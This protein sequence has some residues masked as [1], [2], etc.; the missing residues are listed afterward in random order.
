MTEPHLNKEGDKNMRTLGILGGM[1]HQATAYF[2]EMLSAKNGGK[3]CPNVIIYSKGT[4][5]NL[6]DFVLGKIDAVDPTEGLVEAVKLLERSGATEIVVPSALSHYFL[7]VLSEAVNIPVINMLAHVAQTVADKGFTNVGLLAKEATVH[8]N[9]YQQE[10]LM[11]GI[12]TQTPPADGQVKMERIISCLE[13]GKSHDG[14]AFEA[15]A[16]EL[17]TQG[18]EG[19]ILGCTELSLISR[20][21]AQ[22]FID[23]LNIL[24]NVLYQ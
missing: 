21:E 5:P 10:L 4:P 14:D 12:H 2:Y 1:G 24:T 11:R 13:K 18:A 8:A 17:Y 20:G 15:V 3:N 19:I 9:L 6:T 16:E 23:S 7:P 22:G